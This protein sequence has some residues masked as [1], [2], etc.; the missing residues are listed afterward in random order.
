[1]SKVGGLRPEDAGDNAAVALRPGDRRLLVWRAFLRAHK[2]ILRRLER[3]L[4]S[5]ADISMT[6]YDVLVQLVEAPCNRMRM[7]D[8]ADAVLVTRSAVT[9]VVNRLE[10]DGYVE[11]EPDLNDGRGLFTVLTQKGRNALRAATPIHLRGVDELFIDRLT[12]VQLRQLFVLLALLDSEQQNAG[13][14]RKT[15][16]IVKSSCSGIGPHHRPFGDG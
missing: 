6:A 5:D 7:S 9:R 2:N 11:R 15:A 12:N 16:A 4:Q 8:L 13:P 10:R 3:D 14:Q 1:M